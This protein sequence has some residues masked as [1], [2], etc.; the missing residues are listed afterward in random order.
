MLHEVSAMEK[1]LQD[2]RYATRSLLKSPR[3]TVAAVLTLALGI[4][5]NTAMF[6]VILS[7]LLKP[8]P[9]RESGRLL[10]VSQ[11][12]ADGNGNLF[13]TQDFL[14]W[15]QQG[16]LLARMGAH[17]SWQFNLSSIGAQPERIAGGQVSYDWLP[18]LGVQPML[19]RLFSAQEDVAGSGNFVLLSW[20]LWKDRYG[21]DPR[22]VGKSIQL[23]TAPYTVVGVMPAGFNDFDGKEL[24]WT[25]LQLRR[26]SGIGSSPNFHWLG[27]CIRLPDGV[28]LQ[29]ARGELDAVASRLHREDPAGD[30]GF[31]VYLQ[32]L[33]DA[34]TNDVRPALLMLMGCVGLV[35]LI[36][37]ANVANLLLARGAAR[38]REMAVRT[39]LGASP[40]RVIRQ[41]LTESVI[42]AG[43]GGTA[44]VAIAFLLLR[45]VLAIHPPQVARMEQTTIDGTVLAY[46]LLASVVV[47]ILFGLAPAIEAARMDITNGLREH[48]SSTGRGFGRHRSILVIAETALACMLLICTGLA[49]RS[50][51][52]LR[53]VELGFVAK[54]VLT[55]RVAAPS[56]RKGPQISEFYQQVVE[57]VRAVP[58]VQ[59]AA[60]A[61]DFPLSGTDPS[62]PVLTDNKTAAPVQGEIVTRFRMVGE[63]YFRTLEIALVQGRGFDGRDT[64]DS[65]AVAIVSESL[66]HKYWPGESAIG[67]RLKPNFTGSSWCVVV[68]VAADVRHWGADVAIEPTAYYPYTQVPDSMRSLLEADM[69]IALRSALA[70]SDLLHSINA[71]VAAVNQNVPVYDV[72]TMD[73]LLADSGS[74]RNFDLSLL[75][76]FS[77]LALSL[78]AVGV[79]A[80]MAYSV[81][82]R[83][84]E[85]GI[86]I[87]L[88]AHSQDVLGL[89]LRQG[90][91]L[92][93]AGSVIG[94]GGAF[95]LRKVMANLLYGLSANDPFVL[96]IVPCV[97]VLV[98]LLACWLPA[99]RATKIDP[100]VALR[101]E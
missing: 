44:G 27:S 95:L 93:I 30:V 50:L 57:R 19:G 99:R 80:V 40:L 65:P 32:T 75:G 100:I 82:Q 8:W 22:I 85:I 63:D 67:K 86:R 4:G 83:T 15:K 29:Q 13:S 2:I 58:G 7:V 46:S 12:Q 41:L 73:S 101:Y 53:N 69:G 72:K 38:Q 60:V 39:A 24:L 9:F 6:S 47:G 98:I 10:F 94:V 33:N 81:S 23:D 48:G 70:Q 35:L 34:F 51:W 68:G 87:A 11:R 36:A 28:S 71:A 17:V 92:A 78:A 25:P 20:V 59:S 97:M 84:R 90:A 89:I 55:F 64:A 18:V 37:C 31:G 61:R 26:D 62:M 56:Q 3:F 66:A 79:Y 42:L 16:G 45:G 14:D 21:A 74:L 88:G 5:A 1:L 43:A 52:S 77:L 96:S 54:N 91:R 49:L 76:A